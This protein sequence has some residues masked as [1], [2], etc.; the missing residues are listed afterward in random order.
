MKKNK[1]VALITVALLIFMAFWTPNVSA[2]PQDR[3]I[4]PFHTSWEDSPYEPIGRTNSVDKSKDFHDSHLRV[5]MI[6]NPADK[7]RWTESTGYWYGDNLYLDSTNKKVGQYSIYAIRYKSYSVGAD[8]SHYTAE[9]PGLALGRTH[10]DSEF[11][12]SHLHFWLLLRSDGWILTCTVFLFEDASNYFYRVVDYQVGWIQCSFDVGPSSSGWSTYGNPHWSEINEFRVGDVVTVD[13]TYRSIN[14]DGM[15]FTTTEPGYQPPANAFGYNFGDRQLMAA[16]YFESSYSYCYFNLFDMTA[17][18]DWAPPFKIKPHTFINIW[19]YHK[20]LADCMI[21]A[22][23]YNKRTKQYWTLRDFYY[24][25]AYIV[26]QNE[27]RIHPAHRNNDPLGSWEFASFDLSIIYESDPENWYVT[28]IWIGF[29]NGVDHATGPARTYFDMLFISYGINGFQTDTRAQ[30]S[31]VSSSIIAW[32]WYGP[33]PYGYYNLWLKVTVAGYVGT[34]ERFSPHV[35]KASVGREEAQALKS[36]Q[37][38]GANLTKPDPQKQEVAEFVMDCCYAIAG[39]LAGPGVKAAV[40]AEK[41]VGLLKGATEEPTYE[42]PH[43]VTDGPW[44]VKQDLG[45]VY[46]LV[47]KLVQGMNSISV[48]STVDVYFA[49]TGDVPLVWFW[50][51]GFSVPVTLNFEWSTEPDDIDLVVEDHDVAV[52]KITSDPTSPSPGTLIHFNVTVENQG[53][54]TETFDTSLYYTL[55]ID[56]LIGTQTVTLTSGANTTLTFEWTPN[57]AGRYEIRAEASMVEGEV[58]TADNT[59]TTFVSV[60][61]PS[62]GSVIAAF[63]FALFAPAAVMIVPK[64][65]K[66][67]KRPLVDI[68]AAV[69]KHNLPN[70]RMFV[71]HEWIGRK[72]T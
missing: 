63:I 34:N 72:R 64:A 44:G 58:D 23:L 25:G 32:N 55:K 36:P 8:I 39:V 38:I 65:R 29:D 12:Y 6:Y 10:V 30:G 21:D 16:G 51:Y 46:I 70:N 15:Y 28:K 49:Q 47:P 40:L 13:S 4:L 43:A 69:L 20:E 61:N 7:D 62:S 66:Y 60:A 5:S 31:R 59:R 33:D 57:M 2:E 67:K 35:L 9:N 56:P 54:F 48:T 3:I 53:N 1:I 11:S 24:G 71:R 17:Y 52:V 50:F 45:E 37:P 68:P 22:Q 26:D 42:W 19:Y 18:S 27:V 41:F 14:I